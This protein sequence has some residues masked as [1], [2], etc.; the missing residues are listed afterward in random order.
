ML[1]YEPLKL[2]SNFLHWNEGPGLEWIC[3]RRRRWLKNTE[4]CE[5][6]A[7]FSLLNNIAKIK[8]KGNLFINIPSW[9]LGKWPTTLCNAAI[10]NTPSATGQFSI[11][12]E[13]KFI[14]SALIFL[15]E[16][17]VVKKKKQQQQPENNA[18]LNRFMWF[19]VRTTRGI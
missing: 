12:N 9:H 7:I 8:D 10:A 18:L 16:N 6:L 3:A 5:T 17:Y 11:K 15:S 2:P 4:R 14:Q 19:E 13:Y 1:D